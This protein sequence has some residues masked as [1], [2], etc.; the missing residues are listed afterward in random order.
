MPLAI[1]SA[2]A[3]DYVAI[4]SVIDSWWGRSV[5]PDLPRLLLEHFHPSSYV[6]EDQSGLAAFLVGFRSPAQPESA[7]IHVVAVRPDLRSAGVGRDLYDRFLAD[8]QKA[9]RTTVSAVTTPGN[10]SSLE[11]HRRMGFSVEGPVVDYHGPG[12]DRMVFVRRL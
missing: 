5:L 1:R 10:R 2:R 11:F 3:D 12:R 4:A 9:G 8:A 6:A 7:Y